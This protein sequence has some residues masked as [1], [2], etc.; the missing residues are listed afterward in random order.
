MSVPSTA[1]LPFVFTEI[2]GPDI[3]SLSAAI[4]R[5]GIPPGLDER[6]RLPVINIPLVELG[7][8]QLDQKLAPQFTMNPDATDL[9]TEWAV[10]SVRVEQTGEVREPLPGVPSGIP[11]V[12]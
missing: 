3:L 2:V 5:I 4:D 9:Y 11:L 1:I 10:P 8:A 7:H 12:S 6:A